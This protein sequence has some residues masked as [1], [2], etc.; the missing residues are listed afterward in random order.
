MSGFPGIAHK[1]LILMVGFA[2]ILLQSSLASA[3]SLRTEVAARKVGVGQSFE[4]QVTAVQDDGDPA[5]QSPRLKVQGSAR[6]SGPS[7]GSQ[8]RMTMKNFNFHSETSVIATWTVTPLKTGKV[9]VGP[10]SFQVGSER[11]QGEQ[12]IVEVV[13]QEQRTQRRS[14]FS[15]LGAGRD[16][17]D[18]DP[19]ESFF[20]SRPRTIDDLPLLPQRYSVTH[21]R[22]ETAFLVAHIEKPRA[23]VGEALHL[24]IVAYGSQ[25]N[26]REISPNEPSLA[27]FLSYSVVESSHD[28][29]AY[30]TEIAGRT[31]IAKKLREYI[32]VP[33]KTGTL[34]IGTMVAALQGN[35][36]TYPPQG[37]PHGYN[38]ESQPIDLIVRNAPL[39]GRPA[40]FIEGDVGDY[41]LTAQL[42]PREID[43]GEFAELIVEIS[44]RGQIPSQVLLPE[45]S[46][47]V[48][49]PPTLRGGP[50]VVDGELSGKRILK[51]PLQAKINGHLSLGEV[52]LPYFDPQAGK[53]REARASL[54]T[55]VVNERALPPPQKNDQEAKPTVASLPEVEFSLP[56]RTKL[57]T[58]HHAANPPISGLAWALLYLAPLLCLLFSPLRRLA[59]SLLQGRSSKREKNAASHTLRDADRALSSGDKN[60]CLTLIERALYLAV[61]Q[62]SGQRNRGHLRSELSRH[63]EKAGLPTN[64]AE[65]SQSLLQ[66][67]EEARFSEIA[68]SIK[69]L[70]NQAGDLLRA[71]RRFEKQN[72]R[73][74]QKKEKSP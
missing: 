59:S 14:P 49:D 50:E 53:Y 21:A 6:V 13:E 29:P 39:E 31:Y 26:F 61:D 68:V 37:S 67:C 20:Q 34:R 58:W 1:S 8:R 16:P 42:S 62:V 71:L 74:S 57:G 12:I 22:D 32:I 23:I 64:L 38:V 47:L 54:G 10:G 56:P 63:L 52:R 9:V 28:E 7:I 15:R 70:L 25:G 2:A 36:A 35:R 33:L 18:D 72:K 43:A 4:V 65:Q 66:S 46:G 5:P 55:L 73:R 44:G 69:D 27:D 17:F 24:V 48:W 40:E 51:F 41:Q 11:I 30:R 45:G 60:Q 19:F 3:A